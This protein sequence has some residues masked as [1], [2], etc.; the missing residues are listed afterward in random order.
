[1]ASLAAAKEISDDAAV[2]ADVGGV[3]GIFMLN[4]ELRRE[5]KVYL[6]GKIC[7]S[8]NPTAFSKSLVKHCGASQ[9]GEVTHI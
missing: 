1:M 7:F 4:Q 3:N 8:V 9:V 5:L 2:V 6:S